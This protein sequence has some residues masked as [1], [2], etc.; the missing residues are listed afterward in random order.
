MHLVR[1]SIIAIA[2]TAVVTARPV[3]AQSATDSAGI[4]AAAMNY[5]EGWYSGDADRMARALHPELAK[6]MVMTDAETGH[7][8]LNQMSAM[9]LINNTRAGGGSA[10]PAAAQRKDFH[11]LDIYNGAA[12]ARVD[13]STWVDFLQLA[14]WN[15]EWKIV[16]VLWELRSAPAA[17]R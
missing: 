8:M 3:M 12:V 7:S 10:T 4:H 1:L 15:G 16:N 11:I 2:C 13:A 5:I 14:R 6:R 9:T 17:T